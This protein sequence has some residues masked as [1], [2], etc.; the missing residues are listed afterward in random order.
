MRLPRAWNDPSLLDD[1]PF[2]SSFVACAIAD[3]GPRGRRE[4][5]QNLHAIATKDL[6]HEVRDSFSLRDLR[7]CDSRILVTPQTHVVV[8]WGQL[9]FARIE[10]DDPPDVLLP[11]DDIRQIFVTFY[12]KLHQKDGAES[13]LRKE[14]RNRGYDR[15]RVHKPQRDQVKLTSSTDPRPVRLPRKKKSSSSRRV[16]VVAKKETL[17]ARPNALQNVEFSPDGLATSGPDDSKRITEPRGKVKVS[18]R[19]KRKKA[20]KALHPDQPLGLPVNPI[21]NST[22]S[23]GKLT[24]ATTRAGQTSSPHGLP[25]WPLNVFVKQDAILSSKT[26]SFSPLGASVPSNL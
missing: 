20:G 12:W 21:A 15:I 19:S 3:S 16:S 7:C 8:L 24:S 17:G 13:Y 22:N 9:A 26:C 25:Y 2:C 11:I 1:E 10:P 14:R 4:V 6:K 5:K 23:P 18:R